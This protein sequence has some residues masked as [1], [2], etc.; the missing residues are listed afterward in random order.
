LSSIPAS[1][2]VLT[3]TL[4]VYEVDTGPVG[5]TISVH[6]IT[7]DW[8]ESTVTWNIPWGTAG[9]DFDAAVTSFSPDIK[10]GYQN[11]DVTTVTGEWVSGSRLNYGLLLQASGPDGNVVFKSK[12]GGASKQPQLCVTYQ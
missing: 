9:G 12:E 2:L 1:S 4:S 8:V 6:P 10:Q 7:T 3:A 5:Q 11:L